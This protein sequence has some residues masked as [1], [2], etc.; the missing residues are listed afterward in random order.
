[1]R[2]WAKKTQLPESHLLHAKES[3][4]RYQYST[5]QGSE[6]LIAAQIPSKSLMSFLYDRTI[7]KPLR[8][9]RRLLEKTWN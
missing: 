8:G 5:L 1:M 2:L 9:R 7:Y 6:R 4:K 3:N